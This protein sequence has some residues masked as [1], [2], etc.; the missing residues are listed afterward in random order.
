MTLAG[1]MKREL[2]PA[3]VPPC[4]AKAV[5]VPPSGEGWLH[6]IKYD[7]YRV[8]AQIRDGH[9][10]LLTRNGHDWTEQFGKV[11]D[12][13]RALGLRSAIIDGEAI[14]QDTTGVADFAAL[15]SELKSRRS[16]R[17]VVMAFDLLHLDGGDLRNRPLFER[18]EELHDLLARGSS[19]NLLHYSEH[20]EGDGAE[21]LASAC[22]M[23]V[24]GIV[25]KCRDKPY[26]SG[27][28]GDW[29]KAKCLMA[30]PFVIIGYVNSQAASEAVGSLVLGYYD[31]AQLVYAGRV[32][33]GF[34]ERVA[35]DLWQRLQPLI[36]VTPRLAGNL[37]REQRSGV[38]WV[39]PKL[40]A[41]IEYR[42]WTDDGI[43]RHAVFR[44]LRTDKTAREIGH[45]LS[46][47]V[48]RS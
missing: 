42:A 1:S 11:A 33:T 13:F 3:F 34:T 19:P 4:L 9:V 24:E 47:L 46:V 20:M 26:R 32:G 16:A 14:V 39:W 37:A 29:L 43:L 22:R 36:M 48:A 8:Q 6:E 15:T 38:V 18:K 12:D 27:R 2:W 28:G 5:A 21:I 45:P 40:V 17:I 25:S 41:R 35:A 10:R 44:G 31:G 7:G 30:D 23:G